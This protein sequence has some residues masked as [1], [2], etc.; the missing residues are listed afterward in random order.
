MKSD[1]SVPLVTVVLTVFKRTRYLA[2]AISSVLR[3]TLP[4]LELIVTDDGDT[5]AA[6]LIC[7]KFQTDARLR[8]R[9]NPHA[10][11][12]PLNIAKA[13][14][15]ARGKYLAIL[16]DDD[17]IEP[18]MLKRLVTSLECDPSLVLAFGNYKVIDHEGRDMPNLTHELMRLRSREKLLSGKVD[19]PFDFALRHGLMV[20]MGCIFRRTA[21][22]V[23]W[24]VPEV[25]GA[26]DYWLTVNLARTG[27][28]FYFVSETL[29]AW[30]QHEDSESARVSPEKPAPEVFIY[31]SLSRLDLPNEAQRFVKNQLA[32]YLNSLGCHRLLHE[33]KPSA[34]RHAILQSLRIRPR[35]SGLVYFAISFFP[36]NRRL[37]VMNLWLRFRR[38]LG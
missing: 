14:F 3:Q 23:N 6:R 4:S 7:A 32:N 37:F 5:E 20:G 27:G 2:E 21:C 8:Y 13:L 31:E 36:A 38:K 26:Y 19:Q 28:G 12:V 18:D 15:E 35:P 17:L 9:S 24:L 16:N 1:T 34:A 10:L 22:D 29:M 25:A 33:G 30:R 11:G